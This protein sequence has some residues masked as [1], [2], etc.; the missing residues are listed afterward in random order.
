MS[1]YPASAQV[2]HC[3]AM[4]AVVAQLVYQL[5]P[6]INLFLV[7]QEGWLAGAEMSSSKCGYCI[8]LYSIYG[9]VADE[10]CDGLCMG[11]L[12]TTYC[13]ASQGICQSHRACIS[14]LCIMRCDAATSC[15]GDKQTCVHANIRSTVRQI[16]LEICQVRSVFTW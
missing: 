15:V 9:T 3:A 11:G 16:C 4:T 6:G 5:K 2:M 10:E 12:C 1:P 8:A 7:Y 13:P 14:G